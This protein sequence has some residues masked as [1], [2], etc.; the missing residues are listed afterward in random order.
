MPAAILVKDLK[1]PMEGAALQ[2]R[3]LLHHGH[4]DFHR[5]PTLV[6]LHEGLGSIAQWRDFPEAL[7]RRTKLPALI[8]DRLGHG[9]SPALT[10]P[11]T[12]A[13]LEVE[14]Y[15]TLPQVLAATGIAAPVL[16]GHSDGGTIALLYAARFPEKV[17]T[18]LSEAAHVFLEPLTIQGLCAARTAYMGGTLRTKLERMHGDKVDSLFRGWNDTWLNPA[19]RDWDITASL[20]TLQCPLLLIQGEGDAYGSPAQIQAV[21]SRVQG[22]V[23][24]LLI[25]HCGH[26][27]HLQAQELVLAHMDAF[28][29]KFSVSA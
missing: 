7:A 17:T 3:W 27:P 25:P 24:S 21:V 10:Q 9:G 23:E 15:Q 22:P 12:M 28:L 14:A 16:V 2:A 8:Y 13:Y 6:F 26:S 1:L 11:R 4:H 29:R 18:V 5:E 20:T 19:A